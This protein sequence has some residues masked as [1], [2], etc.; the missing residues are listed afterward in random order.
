MKDGRWQ[1]P[2]DTRPPAGDSGVSGL[3]VAVSFLFVAMLA[4][5]SFLLSA[6]IFRL[7]KRVEALELKAGAP[8]A[9]VKGK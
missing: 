1:G 7:I 9:A 6:D 8:A 2:P 3:A 5:W 4:T